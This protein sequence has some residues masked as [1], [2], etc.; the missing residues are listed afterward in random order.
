MFR[1]TAWLVLAVHTTWV[2]FL[3]FLLLLGS[4]RAYDLIRSP[5]RHSGPHSTGG[6]PIWFGSPLDLI[7]GQQS[8]LTGAGTV[9][10]T[11]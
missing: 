11:G 7:R 5:L 1:L 4:A 9:S 8:P 10:R 6:A 3:S 2:V